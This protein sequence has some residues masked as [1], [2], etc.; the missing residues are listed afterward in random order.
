MDRDRDCPIDNPII[1]QTNRERHAHFATLLCAARMA[2][3]ERYVNEPSRKPPPPPKI[4]PHRPATTPPR[5]NIKIYFPPLPFCLTSVDWRCIMVG[6]LKFAR[7][8]VY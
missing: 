4:D 6:E 1:A 2:F 8:D 5:K 7:E 3:A